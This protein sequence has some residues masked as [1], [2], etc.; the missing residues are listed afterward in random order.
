MK[1]DKGS[2][3][4]AVIYG[5]AMLYL[6][7][8]LVVLQGPF[9]RKLKS[10]SPGSQ[11]A[12]AREEA[13]GVAARVYY[14]PVLLTQIDR[15][16]EKRLWSR[17]RTPEGLLGERLRQARMAALNEIFEEHLLRIKVRFNSGEFEV[18]EEELA[19]E[20]RSFKKRFATEQQLQ[21]AM[22]NQGWEGEA[23][24]VARVRA[25]LEQE[26][27]L[28]K[29]VDFSV[30][31]AE[32]QEYYEKNRWRFELP[33]RV[34]VRHIFFAALDHPD[35][36]ALALA[37]STRERLVNGEGFAELAAKLSEDPASKEKGGELSWMARNRLSS[38]LRDALFALSS[39]DSHLVETKLG[40]HVIEILA[41]E[42][43]RERSLEEIADE[44]REALANQRRDEGVKTYLRQLHHRES[45]KLELFSDV[46]DRPW[47]L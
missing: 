19:Q 6:L 7:L 8:D 22:A 35:G 25:K 18:S 44:L 31:D 39:G 42:P 4:R 36:E 43:A 28:D 30:S 15:A 45:H 17:G 33:E 24:L 37:Q 14:Q 34:Q 47:S 46:L 12:I 1:P 29:F 41:K 20:V 26:A 9:Y 38:E 10:S 13:R 16:V 23:E 2:L 40:V 5:V 11:E 32:L 3:V 27:Y 21:E